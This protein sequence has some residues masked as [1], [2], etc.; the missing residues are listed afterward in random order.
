MKQSTSINDGKAQGAMCS[1]R[2]HA[3]GL[4]VQL[5]RTC[6]TAKALGSIPTTGG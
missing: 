1:L 3:W 5:E 6:L 2:V 4:H